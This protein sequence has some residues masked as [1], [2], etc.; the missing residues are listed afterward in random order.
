M[1]PKQN[2]FELIKSL[3]KSEK[4]YF[5]MYASLQKGSKNYL[6][7]FDEIEK[8][9]HYDELQL[10]VKFKNE[11]F[12]NQL[13]FTKN[14]LYKLILKSLTAYNS[15]ESVDTRINEL[16]ES[17]KIL[18]K[19]GLTKQYNELIINAITLAKEH[20]RFY[21]HLNLIDMQIFYDKITDLEPLSIESI[22]NERLKII[23]IINNFYE[24]NRILVRLMEIYR[25]SGRA[26]DATV[27]SYL[28]KILKKKIMSSPSRALSV[29]AK[30][31]YFFI[32]QLIA[33]FQG[34]EKS[35]LKYDLK[36]LEL[37]QE[38]PLPFQ[39][40]HINYWQDVLGY[41]LTI[42]VRTRDREKFAYYSS[43][44]DDI[45]IKNPS[46]RKLIFILKSYAA[47]VKIETEKKWEEGLLLIPVIKKVLN[48]N[49]GK[50]DNDKHLL[51]RMKIM[52]IFIMNGRYNEALMEYNELFQHPFMKS[53]IELD[54]YTRLISVIIHYELN[55]SKFL[56]SHLSSTYLY[57]YKKKKLYMV[58]KT[59]LN[60]IKKLPKIHSHQELIDVLSTLK[61]RLQKFKDEPF[62]K[63]AFRYFNFIEWIDKKL[64]QI[65][66]KP[67]T[68]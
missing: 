65:E 55:D 18:F 20:E 10:K 63:N 21:Q 1:K 57:L 33:D 61:T 28:Q 53:R 60:F 41:A 54:W 66:N 32:L 22:N 25:N 59:L 2:L 15:Q 7:L 30:E 23:G 51:M 56:N 46:D 38:N 42:S 50:L 37:L 39:G 40:L 67:D 14:Y 5:K 68:P 62:E 27:D 45:A 13:T 36:R 26:R 47:L 17:A 6:K 11:K 24:Y 52:V 49:E 31:N 29:R 9:E 44:L 12:I 34:D 58:E 48:Q 64:S 3:N 8:N 43:L 19:K 35:I 16:I 4:R